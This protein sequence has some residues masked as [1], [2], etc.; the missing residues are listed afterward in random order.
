MFTGFVVKVNYRSTALPV[1]NVLLLIPICSCGQIPL[2]CTYRQHK[3]EF[4]LLHDIL[5]FKMKL[6]NICQ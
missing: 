2:Q 1:N 6:V 4:N 5:V 3:W